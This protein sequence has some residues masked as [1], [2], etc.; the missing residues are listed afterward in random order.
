MK[1]FNI[2][3][4]FRISITLLVVFLF[5]EMADIK[6]DKNFNHPVSAAQNNEKEQ[7]IPPN[8]NYA[9]IIRAIKIGEGVPI[10]EITTPIAEEPENNTSNSEIAVTN[11][12]EYYNLAKETVIQAMQETT[13]AR[14]RQ[15]VK[16]AFKYYKEFLK[17]YPEDL[18]GMLG[19]GAM[20]TYLGRED[21]ARNIIMQAYAMYPKN[22]RVHKA[23][24]DY[25]FKFSNY[26]NAIDYYNLSLSSGN[27]KD[28]S[29]NL[30]AAVCYEKLGDIERAK[31]YFLVAQYLNPD[32]VIANQRVEMYKAMEREG[33]SADPRV[34]DD[35]FKPDE[36]QDIELEILILDAQRIK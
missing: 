35:A 12:K 36:S 2:K 22:P 27:L 16:K 13:E 19:A 24:G 17:F 34:Y 32:S 21:D 29:T 25:S 31:Q 18:E 14:T 7:Y 9:E 3:N 6:T 5:S 20:A 26:N 15:K 30:A 28:Y 8:L 33:Y 11:P 1:N 4:F 10:E 23:L